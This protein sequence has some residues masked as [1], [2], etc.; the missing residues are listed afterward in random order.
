MPGDMTS[1]R[2]ERLLQAYGADPMRWPQGERQAALALLAAD[3]ALEKQRREAA[4]LD[5]LLDR[6][7]PPQASGELL[8]DILAAA[9]PPSWR[10]WLR[11]TW[12]FGPLWQPASGLALAALAGVMVGATL[13]SPADLAGLTQIA[14]ELEGLV[15]G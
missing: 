1:Q 12:P 13:T 11:A 15:L 5:A 8:G 3:P 2:L 9:G 6:A 10:Q 7:E 14:D 4:A